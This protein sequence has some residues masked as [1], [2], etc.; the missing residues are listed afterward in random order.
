[1][2]K[3]IDNAQKIQI[4]N[5]FLLWATLKHN[6][7]F[8]QKIYSITFSVTWL[9]NRRLDYVTCFLAEIS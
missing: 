2:V 6:T 7:K 5:H 3:M 1:M 4:T 8:H 9:T